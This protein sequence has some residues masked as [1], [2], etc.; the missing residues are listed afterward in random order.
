MDA[1]YREFI[2]DAGTTYKTVAYVK[3][4]CVRL[5]AQAAEAAVAAGV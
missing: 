5:A 3:A 4:E 1:R 2:H